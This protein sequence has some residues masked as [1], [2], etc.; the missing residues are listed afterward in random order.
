MKAGDL[1]Q[2]SSQFTPTGHGIVLRRL[3]DSTLPSDWPRIV[4][5]WNYG[6]IESMHE[7]DLAVV[8]ESR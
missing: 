1:I 7:E 6:K 2:L 4:V 3:I 5:L 8:N